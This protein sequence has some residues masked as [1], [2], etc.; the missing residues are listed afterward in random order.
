MK[1]KDEARLGL[2]VLFVQQI[3]I[4]TYEGNC[5]VKPI[6]TGRYSLKWTSEL[7]SLSR[8]VRWLFNNCPTGRNSQS[9]EL[10]KRGSVEI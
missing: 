6:R 9:S 4:S 3:L 2:A 10:Y 8:E 1:M 5:P 7:R